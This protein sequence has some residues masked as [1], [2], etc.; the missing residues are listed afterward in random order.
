MVMHKVCVVSHASTP[1]YMAQSRSVESS[2][3]YCPSLTSRGVVE[4]R[5]KKLT[6]TFQ[7][8]KTSRGNPYNDIVVVSVR[9]KSSSVVNV[10]DRLVDQLLLDIDYREVADEFKH[11]ILRLLCISS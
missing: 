11:H 5:L 3:L 2:E 4:C 10:L 7:R 6:N 1:L 9:C 8:M